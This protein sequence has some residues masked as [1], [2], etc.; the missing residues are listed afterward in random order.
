LLGVEYQYAAGY[1]PEAFVEA[2]EKLHGRDLQVQARIAKALPVA[3]K[4]PLHNQIARAFANYPPTEERI[5]KVQAE[6]STLLPSRN[7][8]IFDTSE[9]QKVKAKLAWADRP[10]L[11]RQRAGD[12]PSNGPVLHRP[13]QE[14]Q[15]Q[16][17]LGGSSPMVTKGRLSSV[18]SYLPDFP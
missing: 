18:F 2:L 9:F 14:L 5:E 10:I 7:D 11:R 8:Y 16:S 3:A 12:G 13:S 17:N 6:I 4:V 15:H 1:D